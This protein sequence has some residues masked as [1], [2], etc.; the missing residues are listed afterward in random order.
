MYRLSKDENKSVRSSAIASIVSVFPHIPNKEQAWEV[1]H[2]LT[3]SED[4]FKRNCGALALGSVFS[5]LINKQELMDDLLRLSADGDR[6]VRMNA[7]H[8]LGKISIL[9]ASQENNPEDYRKE[10][11]R[12]IIYFEQASKESIKPNPAEFCLPFYRSFHAILFE[13][14]EAREEVDKCLAETK[15]VTRGSKRRELLFE[16]VKN[17]SNALKEVQ[18]LEDLDLEAKKEELNF[19]RKYCDRA[20]ELMRDTEEEAPFATATMRKGL[21][22]LD[23]KIKSL[24][25]E[26]QEKAK[27]ACWE[28]QGTDNKEI[29]IAVNKEVQKWEL[30]SQEEMTE[31]IEELLLV[32]ESKIPNV[33]ENEEVLSQIKRMR[34]EKEI[35]KQY[36]ILSHIIP[37]IPLVQTE[38]NAIREETITQNKIRE[39]AEKENKVSITLNYKL[40]TFALLS[41]AICA[42]LI[43]FNIILS[44]KEWILLIII[45]SLLYLVGLKFGIWRD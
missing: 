6:T 33:P 22:I 5:H 16:A 26:I 42:I 24:L 13:R 35:S 4:S 2:G 43:E 1:L 39:K 40:S 27:N 18:K 21:P 28:S 29:A 38:V 15:E 36:K 31:K 32:L 8:S 10:L 23:R 45:I 19:Y 30:C 44:N 9:K 17:L 25:E 34:T 3:N 12:A 7:N 41:L 37:L 20:A 14:E 11:E